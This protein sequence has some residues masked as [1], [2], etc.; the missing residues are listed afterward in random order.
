MYESVRWGVAW[1]TMSKETREREGEVDYGI[2]V[3][4]ADCR[5]EALRPQLDR[6]NQ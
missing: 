3:A 6:Q 5:G 4:L 2:I 1:P